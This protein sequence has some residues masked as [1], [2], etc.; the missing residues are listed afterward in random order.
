VTLDNMKLGDEDVAVEEVAWYWKEGG[1]TIVDCTSIGIG[2]DPRVLYRVSRATN[3]HVVMGAG[4]YL[5]NAHPSW[6][7]DL[8]ADE[9]AELFVRDVTVGVDGTGVRSGIIG[10][11]GT[12]GVP[13]NSLK[14]IGDI[15][16]EE[17]KVLRAAGRAAVRTGVAVSVHLDRRGHGAF[18]IIDILADEGVAPDRMVMGHLDLVDDLDYHREV[19]RQGVFLEYDSIGRE[20]HVAELEFWGI[21]D[22]WRANALATLVRE[23]WV[24][25]LVL[26]QDI[27]LKIDLRRFGGH[28]YAHILASFL[29]MLRSVGVAE[30][31]IYRML[32]INPRRILT[33]DWSEELLQAMEHD[34]RQ[35]S[36][37]HVQV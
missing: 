23:G 9:L 36:H 15:T 12:G 3:V 21:Q 28:G 29:P 10:E 30:D 22:I 24:D 37:E 31:A 13:K 20:H 26:S 14:K 17:E 7:R 2:R 11:I 25:Q 27:C 33:V 6:V 32:V 18:R 16:A 4:C 8:T 34:V 1:Q 19:A 5:E 35:R